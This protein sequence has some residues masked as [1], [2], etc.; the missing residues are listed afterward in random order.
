MNVLIRRF[1]I[2]ALAL[3]LAVGC[4]EKKKDFGKDEPKKTTPAKANSRPAASNPAKA[5]PPE[6]AK[7]EVRVTELTGKVEVMKGDTWATLNSG[8]TFEVAAMPMFRTGPDSKLTFML[9]D[10]SLVTVEPLTVFFFSENERRELALV[11]GVLSIQMKD[12]STDRAGMQIRTRAGLIRGPQAAFTVAVNPLGDAMVY[13]ERGVVYAGDEKTDL[14]TQATQAQEAIDAAAKGAEPPKV[15]K[16]VSAYTKVDPGKLALLTMGNPIPQLS[17]SQ[18]A[19]A[20]AP[21]SAPTPAP[22]PAPTPAPKTPA[23]ALPAPSIEAVKA[24][25]VDAAW[26]AKFGK[27]LAD[28]IKAEEA[29]LTKI[30]ESLTKTE[31]FKENNL[32]QIEALKTARAAKDQA[33][34]TKIQSEI[35]RSSRLV[36]S[37]KRQ[38]HLLA[39]E[40]FIQINNIDNVSA[41]AKEG[42][43]VKK[44]IT[45]NEA[46]LTELK[47]KIVSIRQKTANLRPRTRTPSNIPNPGARPIPPA[48]KGLPQDVIQPPAN[49]ISPNGPK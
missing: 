12:K 34:I 28:W 32:K 16:P 11:S 27:A 1:A 47:G 37:L 15:E 33:A 30:D 24:F 8:E 26:E 14:T 48:M 19:P 40:S 23:S 38:G 44:A 7:P 36:L 20:P 25:A 39:L 2:G 41:N 49:M 45:A 29:N 35:T 18:A 22:K 43:D 17:E 13:V 4:G 5:T 9:P 6:P 46:K 42:S 31:S 3:S 21:T 10:D